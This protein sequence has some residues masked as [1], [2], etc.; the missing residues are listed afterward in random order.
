MCTNQDTKIISD[1]QNIIITMTNSSDRYEGSNNARMYIQNM[2]DI[3]ANLLKKALTPVI[4]WNLISKMRKV[5]P[6]LI[7]IGKQLQIDF[8]NTDGGKSIFQNIITKPYSNDKNGFREKI[9]QICFEQNRE[10]CIE[11]MKN[12]KLTDDIKIIIL[13][14]IWKSKGKSIENNFDE[15]FNYMNSTI[16]VV[17]NGNVIISSISTCHIGDDGIC[18]CNRKK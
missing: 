2:I 13:N 4:Y 14:N 17:G 1:I 8:L 12:Q 15:L 3:N 11:Q 7:N 9:I 6:D 16:T 5:A 18:A 10:Q